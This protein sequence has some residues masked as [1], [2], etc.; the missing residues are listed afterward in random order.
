MLGPAAPSPTGG[1]YNPNLKPAVFN[2][3]AAVFERAGHSM[4]T[5]SFLRIQNDGQAAPG[6]PVTLLEGFNNPSKLSSSNELS[7]FL[8]GL[9]VEVQDET[10]I[11][12]VTDMRLALLDAFDIQRARDHGLPDYNTLRQAY[13]L[14]SVTS[15]ADITSDLALRQALLALSQRQRDRPARGRAGRRP[16][17]GF[18]RRPPRR[19]RPGH[20]VRTLRDADRFWYERD[21]GFT[22][23]ELDTLL[24]T[25]LSD[26]I[27]RNTD[28]TN[29]QPNVFFVPEPSRRSSCW[30]SSPRSRAAERSESRGEE[31]VLSQKGLGWR[32]R[33][34][35]NVPVF[36]RPV[37]ACVCRKFV[38]KI[39]SLM[40][41]TPSSGQIAGALLGRSVHRATSGAG[42][43]A[44]TS[45]LPTP[46]AEA[47]SAGAGRR[48]GAGRE[49]RS[50]LRTPPGSRRSPRA[51][52]SSS[53]GRS[54]RRPPPPPGL[55]AFGESLLGG[56]VSIAGGLV[57]FYCA[58]LLT[59][60]NPST[61]GR[62]ETLTS[63][64]VVLGLW[65]RG[66]SAPSCTPSWSWCRCRRSCSWGC[67]S[68]TWRC[69]GRRPTVEFA[70]FRYL[71]FLAAR[72]PDERLRPYLRGN[73]AAWFAGC[74]LAMA[75]GGAAAA[76]L[77]LAIPPSASR[78]APASPPPP[79]TAAG[80]VF[81]RH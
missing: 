27:M 7:L 59:T 4:L 55:S 50:A 29:L 31:P 72:V 30:A 81:S 37:L 42:N 63:R 47:P 58:G 61:F 67:R 39:R 1:Q 28:L 70:R 77:A 9:S 41:A 49:T 16:P 52:A 33:R 66:W 20:P 8:K 22:P 14:P 36:V 24:N 23:A 38:Q 3:F 21:P 18:Q 62:D 56:L 35:M 5:P 53:G 80:S 51:C 65:P 10:D 12:I 32:L 78:R 6:G 26:V 76:P 43:A 2:E 60:P 13:G 74:V 69:A 46:A 79:S 45:A 34:K 19:R 54:S 17:P 73:S 25:R 48:V 15:F 44:T 11:K 75:L 71:A 68:L 57:H 40:R 64:K